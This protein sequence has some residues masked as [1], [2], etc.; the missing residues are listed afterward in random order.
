MA[1]ECGAPRCNPREVI[2]GVLITNSFVALAEGDVVEM[3][4]T[5]IIDWVTF[6]VKGEV[7][8]ENIITNILRM[9][10]QLFEDTPYGQNG[11][12]RTM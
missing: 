7:S 5:A 11:Y 3:K 8:A 12:R 6:S 4:A 10:K 2:T 1:G 9:D